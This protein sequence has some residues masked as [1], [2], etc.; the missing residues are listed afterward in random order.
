MKTPFGRTGGKSRIKKEIVLLFPKDFKI[1]VEPFVGAGS[2]FFGKE[3]KNHLEIL[4]DKDENPINLIKLFKET[5]GNEISKNINNIYI[6]EDFQKLLNDKTNTNKYRDLLLNKLSFRCNLRSFSI[7]RRLKPGDNN[8]IIKSK[9]DNRYKERLKDVILLN[10]DYKD[11]IDKYD[12][13]DTFFYLDPPYEG[14]KKD[15]IFGEIN[16]LDVFNIVDNIK[17]KFLLSYNKSENILKIFNKFNIKTINTTY[18]N[19]VGGG[20]KKEELLIYNYVL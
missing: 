9:Y 5:D 13:P 2:V 19:N 11:I 8:N 12:S 3:K 7:G 20:L 17:G 10:K 1:Y 18:S 4:N 14:A 6:K 15:Y 16:P